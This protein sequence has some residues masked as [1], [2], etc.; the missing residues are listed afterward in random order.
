[1]C[2]CSVYS[3][4]FSEKSVFFGLVLDLI[5]VGQSK[6]LMENLKKISNR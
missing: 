2:I 3:D 1:M 5:N 4:I 6:M